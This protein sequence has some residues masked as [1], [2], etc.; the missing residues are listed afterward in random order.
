M[1][2]AKAKDDNI[3]DH[4]RCNMMT[5]TMP[6]SSV[7]IGCEVISWYQQ[8]RQVASD[9]HG[10]SWLGMDVLR[11]LL[12]ARDE[13]SVFRVGAFGKLSAG[14]LWETRRKGSG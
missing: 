5:G 13:R 6:G 7:V 1:A 12:D 2:H 14:A 4:P 8:R 10:V 9:T 11:L 3:E